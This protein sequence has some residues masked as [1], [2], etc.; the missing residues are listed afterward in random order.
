MNP[1]RWLLPVVV[2]AAPCTAA[3]VS[4]PDDVSAVEPEIAAFIAKRAKQEDPG[5]TAEPY[6]SALVRG[7]IDGDG[8]ADAL[9]AYAIEGIGGGNFSLLFLA[10]FERDGDRLVFKTERENGSF[11]TASGSSFIPKSIAK[12]K[13]SGELQTYG[14]DDAVCCPSISKPAVMPYS[15]GKL[16]APKAG[17]P[18]R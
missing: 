13:I 5:G 7:D 1:L 15:K 11:G 9:A 8:D 6:V 12:G 16:R 4:K 17:A 10:L 3:E 2:I 18:A 14:P